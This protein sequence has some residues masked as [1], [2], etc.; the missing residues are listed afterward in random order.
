MAFVINMFLVF[1]LGVL[2]AQKFQ[3]I[4]AFWTHVDL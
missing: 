4:R 2:A 3:Y 1:W